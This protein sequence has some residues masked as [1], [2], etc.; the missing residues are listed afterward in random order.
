MIKSAWSEDDFQVGLVSWDG[1]TVNR[2]LVGFQINP[3]LTLSI[4]E[5]YPNQSPI[6]LIKVEG[7]KICLSIR[8]KL[9]FHFHN[10]RPLCDFQMW[11]FWIGRGFR[12]HWPVTTFL[13][14]NL[15]CQFMIPKRSNRVHSKHYFTWCIL[16]TT[17][18][19]VF[20]SINFGKHWKNCT[21]SFPCPHYLWNESHYRTRI[22]CA[23]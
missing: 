19:G 15:K 10:K 12:F 22:S 23:N 17:S 14:H 1:I 20:L 11:K 5:W 13:T 3:H 21:F 8:V 2:I 16:S 7:K 18:H 9:D 4:V 6:R